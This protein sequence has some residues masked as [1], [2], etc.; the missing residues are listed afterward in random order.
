MY[1]PGIDRQLAQIRYAEFLEE[2]AHERASK[3]AR[4][5]RPNLPARRL[6]IALAAAA[7]IVLWIIWVLVA[8]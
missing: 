2:A 3:Q 6:A 1:H 7:P 8:G 4:A 5:V